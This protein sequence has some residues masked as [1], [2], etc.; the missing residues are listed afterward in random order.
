MF[1]RA[2]SPRGPAPMTAT[3]GA[4]ICSRLGWSGCAA[5]SC[6][7][8]K[9]SEVSNGSR[10]IKVHVGATERPK[11]WIREVRFE[12]SG[13]DKGTWLD[14]FVTV[15]EPSIYASSKMGSGEGD[16]SKV[17]ARPQRNRMLV[18]I[19]LTLNPSWIR[20]FAVRGALQKLT[21]NTI[22]Y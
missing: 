20:L 21:R 3:R 5:S 22:F 2:M 17:S 8:M 16:I 10:K 1:F 18:W 19:C 11:I 13:S 12:R 14:I 9:T 6:K 7:S 15:A 4:M